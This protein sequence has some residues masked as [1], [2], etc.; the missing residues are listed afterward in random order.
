MDKSGKSHVLMSMLVFPDDSRA[1]A[2]TALAAWQ[3][4]IGDF[5][6]FSKNPTAYLAAAP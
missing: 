2:V 4:C 1:H 6:T 3:G 5:T